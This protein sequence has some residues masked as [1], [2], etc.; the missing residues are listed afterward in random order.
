MIFFLFQLVAWGRKTLLGID[1]RLDLIAAALF[2]LILRACVN[3][4]M[5]LHVL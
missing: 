2:I 3:G 4:L 1:K 5:F